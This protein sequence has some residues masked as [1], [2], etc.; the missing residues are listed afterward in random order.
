M[1]FNQLLF[2]IGVLLVL[3]SC[4]TDPDSLTVINSESFHEKQVQ[5]NFQYNQAQGQDTLLTLTDDQ[6]LILKDLEEMISMTEQIRQSGSDSLWHKLT[7][8]WSEFD[9]TNIGTGRRF[10]TGNNFAA[11]SLKGNLFPQAALKWAQLNIELVKLSEEVRYSDALEILLYGTKGFAFPEKMLKSVIY[12]HVFDQIY[13]N[14]LGSSSMEYQH[15]TGGTVKLIQETGY[16][17]GNEMILKCETADVRYMDFFIRIPS[18]AVNPSVSY[19]IV[20]YVAHPGEY[21]EISK[22]WEKGDEVRVVLRQ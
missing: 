19:G 20:K 12:T 5:L 2:S 11:D 3:A 15:T 22:K 8:K 9:S 16:P 18:W 14:I 21:T 7:K 10:Y 4:H 1:K 6:R 17:K 13:V